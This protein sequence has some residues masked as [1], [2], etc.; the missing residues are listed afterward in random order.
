MDDALEAALQDVVSRGRAAWPG[1]GLDPFV[2]A[3]YLGERAPVMMGGDP[4][5]PPAQPVPHP[6]MPQAGVDLVPWLDGLPAGDVFL[7][8]ACA[9][10]LAPALR[11]FDAAFCDKIDVYLRALRPT[12]ELVAETRQELLEKLFVGVSGKPPTILQYTGQ[13]ALGGWV[14]ISAVRTALNLLASEKS[15]QPRLDEASEVASAMVPDSDPELDLIRASC[16]EEFTAAF[17][18]AMASLSRRDRSMLRFTFIERVLPARIA[19]IYGV[20]RTTVMRWIDAAQEE[21]L[22]RTRA[23]MMERLSLTTSECDRIF[24]L[25]KSRMDISIRSLLNTEP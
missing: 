16:K 6:E 23:L 9:E 18:E 4:P 7:A 20:H 1:V 10:G 3:A 21:V 19:A 14:R 8:C 22:A 12:P 5:S 15:N 17:R 25:V 24:S 13:G 2:L 11:A